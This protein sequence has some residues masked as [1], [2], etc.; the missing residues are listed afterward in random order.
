MYAEQHRASVLKHQFA[1]VLQAHREEQTRQGA[2]L[3]RMDEESIRAQQRE[4][5]QIRLRH[6]G[7]FANAEPQIETPIDSTRKNKVVGGRTLRNSMPA[8]PAHPARN[9]SV[10]PSQ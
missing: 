6:N 1:D 9:D 2:R 10:A 8:H 5:E 3:V 7:S 4:R